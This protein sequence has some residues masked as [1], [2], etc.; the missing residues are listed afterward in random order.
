MPFKPGRRYSTSLRVEIQIKTMITFAFCQISRNPNIWYFL[1][2]TMGQYSLSKQVGARTGLIL[3]EDNLA[4]AI[5]ITNAKT[6]WPSNPPLGK[7]SI[8]MILR[9]MQNDLYR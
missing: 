5:K 6:F 1:A 7:Y 9:H 2:G 8:A 4:I 3:W